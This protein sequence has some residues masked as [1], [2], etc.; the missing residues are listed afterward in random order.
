MK[1]FKG[2][3]GEWN[4]CCTGEGEKSHYVFDAVEGVI[5]G[6]HSNDPNDEKGNFESMEPVITIEE[7]QANAKLIAAAPEL[8][9]AL[10]YLV[11]SKSIAPILGWSLAEQAIEKALGKTN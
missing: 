11:K 2:T 8:L 6:M 10:Q 3:N 9:E 7:R 4:A 5:C 1:E